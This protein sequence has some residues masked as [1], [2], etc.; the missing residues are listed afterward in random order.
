MYPGVLLQSVFC[1]EPATVNLSRFNLTRHSMQFCAAV[2]LLHRPAARFGVLSIHASDESLETRKV[3]AMHATHIVNVIR[4]YRQHHGP[5]NTL[6]GTALYN[7]TMAAIVLIACLADDTS[8]EGAQYLLS[9]NTCVRGLE[10]LES[11]YIVARTVLKQLK[12]LMRRC[13]LQFTPSDAEMLRNASNASDSLYQISTIGLDSPQPKMN[14][15]FKAL[16]PESN[17]VS[18]N[19]ELAGHDFLLAMSECDTLNVMGS[20]SWDRTADTF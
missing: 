15:D 17:D 5:A 9:I 18:P 12:H 7:I 10:D 4:D 1:S 14:E 20:W 13:N 6:L 11:S 16:L 8:I 19:D 3:C 2:I